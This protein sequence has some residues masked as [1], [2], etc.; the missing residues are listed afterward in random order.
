MY[1]LLVSFF[2]CKVKDLNYKEQTF[3]LFNINRAVLEKVF[4]E[5]FGPLGRHID[6]R[7]A[8]REIQS[9][10]HLPFKVFIVCIFIKVIR[11]VVFRAQI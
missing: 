9:G 1:S 8:G 11:W 5:W 3:Y 7:E 2:G 6:A 10:Q 4:A